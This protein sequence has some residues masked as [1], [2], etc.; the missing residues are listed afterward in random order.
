MANKGFVLLTI[1]QKQKHLYIFRDFR[2]YLPVVIPAPGMILISLSKGC[3][4]L[5]ASQENPVPGQFFP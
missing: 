2:E 5:Q 1:Y 3:H 4:R